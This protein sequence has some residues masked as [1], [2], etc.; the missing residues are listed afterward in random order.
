[1][2][3]YDSNKESKFIMY[4]DINNLYGWEMIN[5]LPN[6]EFEFLTK[7]ETNQFNLDPISENSSICY[8]LEGRFKIL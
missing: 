7:K 8:I 3:N 2:K 6:D 5:Y 4:W 1:M